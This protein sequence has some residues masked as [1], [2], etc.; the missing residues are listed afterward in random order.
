MSTNPKKVF[1]AMS[2][3]VDSSV[4]ALLLKNSGYA[5]TGVFM[6][7]YNIDG[8]EERDAEDARR[9]AQKLEIPFYSW[10]FEKEYK[11]A[12][13]DYMIDGYR[14]GITPNP[15]VMCNKHIKFGVF[16]K[17]ALAMGAD[18]IATGHYARIV[19]NDVADVGAQAESR[20]SDSNATTLQRLFAGYD[21][22]KDQSY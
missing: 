9:V 20:L 5:V 7:S 14:R 18:Y 11:Q 22:Q 12:V 1:V 19:Q 4:A 6:R 10:D 13:V 8:C 15:D 16:L 21:Q 17:K 2:G 3:G